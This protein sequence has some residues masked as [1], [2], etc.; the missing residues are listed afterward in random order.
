[1]FWWIVVCLHVWHIRSV[2]IYMVSLCVQRDSRYSLVDSGLLGCL[3]SACYVLVKLVVVG[4]I[5]GRWE[6]APSGVVSDSG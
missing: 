6:S 5:R 1:M 2:L 4:N 3:H